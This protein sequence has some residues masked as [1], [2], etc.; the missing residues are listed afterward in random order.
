MCIA[1]LFLL[2][3][4]QSSLAIRLSCFVIVFLSRVNAQQ[5]SRATQGSS[6]PVR[7]SGVFFLLFFSFFFFSCQLTI[8]SRALRL[9]VC[10]ELQAADEKKS[11][12]PTSCVFAVVTVSAWRTHV[13]FEEGK[14]TN[15]IVRVVFL[16]TF[17]RPALRFRSFSSLWIVESARSSSIGFSFSA[18]FCESVETEMTQERDQKRHQ[19]R[20]FETRTRTPISTVWLP[21]ESDCLSIDDFSWTCSRQLGFVSRLYPTPL[22]RPISIQ[23]SVTWRPT[24]S[25]SPCDT[26]AHLF[27]LGPISVFVS[28]Y[29]WYECAAGREKQ[30]K[31]LI[32]KTYSWT[33]CTTAMT[34]QGPRIHLSGPA[35]WKWALLGTPL[36]KK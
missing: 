31:N 34:C 28:R 2:N 1:L 15:R 17:R 13:M 30:S 4:A 23:Y 24:S 8:H 10:C 12:S 32:E 33:C 22:P 6:T 19:K 36:K 14:S 27:A 11:D 21:M 16:Y 3:H 9:S 26:T 29:T 25:L 20:D 35:T 7:E 5:W 18:F